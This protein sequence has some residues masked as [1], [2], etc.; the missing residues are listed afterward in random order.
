MIEKRI[1]C[2][3][4]NETHPKQE[5]TSAVLA[6]LDKCYTLVRKHLL[7]NLLAWNNLQFVRKCLNKYYDTYDHDIYILDKIYQPEIVLLLRHTKIHV[8]VAPLHIVDKGIPNL[9]VSNSPLKNGQ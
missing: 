2:I 5:S 3:F 1:T 7:N 8:K 9:P 6:V 4:F